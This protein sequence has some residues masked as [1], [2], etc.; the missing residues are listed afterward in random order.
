MQGITAKTVNA[1][2]R[3]HTLGRQLHILKA[4]PSTNTKALALAQKGAAHGT[5][6]VADRQ[7]AGRGRMGRSWFSPPGT[8]LYCSVLFRTSPAPERRSDWLSWLPLVTGLATASAVDVVA[9][10]HPTL[11]WPND[12]LVGHRKTGGILCETGGKSAQYVV[13]GI[14]LN[15]NI[16]RDAFPDD[17]RDLA[18]SL[19]AE[20]RHPIDRAVLLASVLFELETRTDALL[21]RPGSE[22]LDEYSSQCSTFGRQVR[23]SFTD[24]KTLDGRAECIDPDG[25]LEI[26]PSDAASTRVR[27]RAG[28]VLYLQ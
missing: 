13:V 23:V 21:Q 19:S 11:K 2:L 26:A 24:G 10:L 27:V 6:V 3:T 25:S 12:I 22:F 5:V 18:T 8:N 9:N 1:V 20:T 7:T 14:G 15:V 4:I 28:D 17:I 16:P